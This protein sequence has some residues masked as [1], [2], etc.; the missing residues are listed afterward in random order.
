M[1]EYSF[2][3]EHKLGLKNGN[4][5]SLSQYPE[6][7]GAIA[8]ALPISPFTLFSYSPEDIQAFQLKDDTIAKVMQAKKQD[9]RPPGDSTKCYSTHTWK[10]FQM[11]DQLEI[12]KGILFCIFHSPDDR[13]TT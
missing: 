3:I 10:L 7:N 9:G 5:D 4:A 8:A 6:E 13:S 1:S 2:H 11:W 12:S